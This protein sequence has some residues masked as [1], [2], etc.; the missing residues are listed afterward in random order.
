MPAVGSAWALS[1]G[2]AY[3]QSGSVAPEPAEGPLLEELALARGGLVIGLA[4][5]VSHLDAGL[6]EVRGEGL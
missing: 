1:P 5:Q 3:L 6:L 4:L 2:S